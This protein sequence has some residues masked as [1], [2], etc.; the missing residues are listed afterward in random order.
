MSRAPCVPAPQ[1]R[2]YPARGCSWQHYSAPGASQ[3]SPLTVGSGSDRRRRSTWRSPAREPSGGVR[4]RNTSHVARR[5]WNCGAGRGPMPAPPPPAAEPPLLLAPPPGP[6]SSLPAFARLAASSASSFGVRSTPSNAASSPWLSSSYMWLWFLSSPG[7]SRCSVRFSLSLS[8]SPQAT[9]RFSVVVVAPPALRFL[10]FPS[11]KARAR[12][13]PRMC[14]PTMYLFTLPLLS[15]D[16]SETTTSASKSSSLSSRSVTLMRFG[17]SPTVSSSGNCFRTA[18]RN[19]S[20]SAWSL[21]KS[22]RASF[23]MGLRKTRSAPSSLTVTVKL[24]FVVS[25]AS[26]RAVSTA[27]F[28][29]SRSSWNEATSKE[30]EGPSRTSISCARLLMSFSTVIVPRMIVEPI[31]RMATLNIT[32]SSR[33]VASQPLSM[34]KFSTSTLDRTRLMR[35]SQVTNPM[36]CLMLGGAMTVLEQTPTVATLMATWIS[37][38]DTKR[39]TTFCLQSGCEQ[40]FQMDQNTRRR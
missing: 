30:P 34:E 37:G 19:L 17:P 7:G 4:R 26:Q 32:M 1:G 16:A 27:R 11:S 35:N 21:K 2:L 14:I 5:R 8:P 9:C 22:V 33:T 36:R 29:L 24:A 38:G 18:A 6:P 31:S 28:R 15:V 20:F 25:T 13:S 3:V 23:S 10:C 40:K 12:N 39:S